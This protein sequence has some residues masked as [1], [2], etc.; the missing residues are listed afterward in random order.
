[1]LIFDCGCC[2]SWFIFYV[3]VYTF[4]ILNELL[5]MELLIGSISGA[6][7]PVVGY[8]AVTNQLDVGALILFLMLS[9]WQMPHS[10][11]IAIFALMI[12]YQ[13][14]FRYYQ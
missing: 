9:I 7:P 3:V 8:C 14:V 5:F 12:I 11:A 1:M 13:Q 2:R 4:G 6:I 10:F